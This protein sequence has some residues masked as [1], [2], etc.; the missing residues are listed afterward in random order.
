[1]EVYH[2][3]PIEESDL[4][5]LAALHAACLAA[6]GPASVPDPD[7]AVLLAAPATA[8]LCATPGDGPELAAAGWVR[9]S[10]ARA[11]LGGRVHPGHRRRRLGTHLL[12]WGAALAQML[13]QPDT[14]T[15]RNEA[16]TAGSQALYAQEGYTCNFIEQ[17]WMQ[18]D[19]AQ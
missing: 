6:D 16:L 12:H 2:W 4:P 1:M 15:I 17:W 8:L 14:L 9:V 18:R 5:A 13:G 11:R 19:R 10:G 3:R 7:Y